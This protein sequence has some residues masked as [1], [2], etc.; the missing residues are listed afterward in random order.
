MFTIICLVGLAVALV[1]IACRHLRDASRTVE[2]ILRE[3]IGDGDE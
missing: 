3:E 1:Y 2:D